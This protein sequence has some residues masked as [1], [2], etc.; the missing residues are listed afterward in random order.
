MGIA[1]WQGTEILACGHASDWHSAIM[2]IGA[3]VRAHHELFIDLEMEL[4]AIRSNFRKSY[5][6]LINKAKTLWQCRIV[7]ENFDTAFEKFRDL[8]ILV[9]GRETRSQ[10]TWDLLEEAVENGDGFIVFLEDASN[11]LIGAAL[12]YHSATDAVYSVAAYDRDYFDKPVGHLVQMTAITHLKDIGIRNYRLG[13]RP[14]PGDSP[15]PNEKELNIGFFKEG[16]S[17]HSCLN[18]LTL[19]PVRSGE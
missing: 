11:Q 13:Y 17:S 3:T 5:K 2:K 19:A 8:H 15:E 9:A 12:F 1:E 14:Y 16:F 4:S 7:D 10:K 18:L 6:P